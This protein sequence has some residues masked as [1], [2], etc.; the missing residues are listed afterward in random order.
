MP[1]F[2]TRYERRPVRFSSSMPS[3]T[4]QSDLQATLIPNIFQS[5]GVSFETRTPMFGDFTTAPTSLQDAYNRIL[6]AQAGFADLPS[7]V[8][9][10]FGNDPMQLIAFLNDPSNRA[11]AEQLGLVNAHVSPT[12]SAVPDGKSGGTP[13]SLDVTV[14]GD[15]T[16]TTPTKE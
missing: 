9:A 2:L 8:R 13:S 14:P 11:E 4:L 10:R 16:T 3:Q 5:H 6:E 12:A 1:K 15:T 7:N